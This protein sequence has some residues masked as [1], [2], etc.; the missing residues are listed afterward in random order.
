MLISV[1]DNHCSFHKWVS[2]SAAACGCAFPFLILLNLRAHVRVCRMV[3]PNSLLKAGPIKVSGI[4]D[5]LE[6][7]HYSPA[8]FRTPKVSAVRPSS[9]LVEGQDITIEGS[10]FG[11]APSRYEA[12]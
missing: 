5:G 6:A 12:M 9:F 11:G 10:G 8:S 1:G 7:H 2:D 3:S 4:F